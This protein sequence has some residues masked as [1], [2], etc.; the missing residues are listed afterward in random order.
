MLR[1]KF[2]MV[3]EKNVNELA[4]RVFIARPIREMDQPIVIEIKP[5]R[6]IFGKKRSIFG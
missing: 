1:N 5:E 4:K 2:Q 6:K 3:F